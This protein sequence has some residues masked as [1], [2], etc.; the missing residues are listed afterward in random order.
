MKTE[1]QYYDDYT[2]DGLRTICQHEITTAKNNKDKN[3]HI[4]LSNGVVFKIMF[5]N[6]YVV[7]KIS[8]RYYHLSNIDVSI[9]IDCCEC[10]IDEK[11]IVDGWLWIKCQEN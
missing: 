9:I 10:I 4:I 1:I 3:K 5:D 6:G 11:K 8:N 2:I 7:I